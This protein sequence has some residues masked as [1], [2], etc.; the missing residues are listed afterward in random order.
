MRSGRNDLVRIW[1]L[2]RRAAA[3]SARVSASGLQIL[4]ARR[5]HRSPRREHRAGSLMLDAKQDSA[6][7]LRVPRSHDVERRQPF[8]ARARRPVRGAG[9]STFSASPITRSAPTTRGSTGR[10]GRHAA[11]DAR[12]TPRTS[13]TFFARQAA[14]EL[15]TTCSFFPAWPDRRERR[16]SPAGASRGLEDAA[17]VREGRRGRRRLPPLCPPGLSDSRR[18]RTCTSRCSLSAAGG[19]AV[20][21]R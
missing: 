11:Y 13:R 18:R 7:A 4:V 1:S 12:C 2:G 19:R 5:P 21:V 15:C 3:R 17:S 16:L 20:T 6:A 9:G 10:S 14:P 8:G